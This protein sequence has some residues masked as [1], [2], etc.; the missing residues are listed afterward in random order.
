MMEETIRL[1]NVT[2]VFGEKEN[3]VVALK[4][5]NISIKRGEMV[6][7][8]GPSGSGKSTLLNI[9]GCLD[10]PTVGNYF[11]E[12]ISVKNL[13]Q[14]EI[15]S[16]RNNKFGFVFQDFALLQEYSS[17]DNVILPLTYRNQSYSKS[18]KIGKKYLQKLDIYDKRNKKP[19]EL[20]GGHQQ[21]V[22]IARALASNPAI[23]LAD[24]PT[25]ALDQRTGMDIMGIFRNLNFEGK[26]IIIVTHDRFISSYCHRVIWISDGRV[27]DL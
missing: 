2:K 18:I 10:K 7:I 6:A 24:E 20:S 5:V 11:L 4:N 8:M 9:I 26:T 3:E 25:G 12:G 27:T 17:L 14:N 1:T 16:L 21:K 22:A 23:I 13:S 15:A 19:C